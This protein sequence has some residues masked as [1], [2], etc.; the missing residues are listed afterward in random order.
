VPG[1]APAGEVLGPGNFIHAVSNLD[2]SVDFYH[3]VIGLD[4]PRGRGVNGAP[5]P[6][7]VEAPRPFIATP[8]IL[9][10]YNAVGAQ[11]RTTTPVIPASAMRPELVE[12]KDVDLK[13][14]HPRFVDP[15]A[16]NFIFTVKDI[17]AVMERVKKFGT[18]V[19]TAGGEPIAIESDH[20]KARAVVI[21]DPDGFYIELIQPDTLPDSAAQVTGNI[22]DVG[23]GFT[24]EN[25]DRMVHV[26]KDGLGF[27]PQT[28]SFSKDKTRL[29][30]FGAPSGSQ[31]KRTTAL[32]P[33]SALQVE[34]LEFKGVD[35]KPVHGQQHDP[36]AAVLRLR[37]RDADSAIKSLADT[38]VKV[39]TAD[40]TPIAL[41]NNRFAITSAPDNLFVQVLQ[42]APRPA[43]AAPRPPQ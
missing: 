24:V 10:L 6:P 30:L 20:G 15:G 9:R 1:A 27:T 29:S 26:F 17:G 3:D 28:G 35:G 37:V 16:S 5:P 23:F 25:T 38:G 33:G 22:I 41:G 43:Q 40:G 39:V 32:V 13:P 14:V 18:P 36:G 31:V 7:P 2:K 8:E 42:A 19:V 4:L 34:F 11:F 12:F 21:K